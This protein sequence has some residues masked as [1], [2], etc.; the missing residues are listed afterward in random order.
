MSNYFQPLYLKRSYPI[1]NAINKYGINSF[2]LVILELIGR[3]HNTSRIMK[4]AREDYYFS[5]YLPEYN[6]LEKGSSSLNYKHSIEA[7]AK[8]RAYALKRDKKT[9]VYST[10]FLSKQKSSSKLGRINPM[11]GK[12]WTEERGKNLAKPVYVYD[13]K[14]FDLLNYFTETVIA[15]KELKIGYYTLRRC[16]KTKESY[17]GKLFSNLPLLDKDKNI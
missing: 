8:I 7:R 5:S 12:K 15:I 6:I 4:L 1:I 2:N 13:S 17:K 14:T 3:S 16:L 9:I 11:Y 10:E